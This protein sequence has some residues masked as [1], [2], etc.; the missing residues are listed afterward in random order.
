MSEQDRY[1]NP[2]GFQVSRYRRDAETLPEA[3]PPPAP[4]QLAPEAAE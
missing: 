4:V 2:L 3:A 1:L